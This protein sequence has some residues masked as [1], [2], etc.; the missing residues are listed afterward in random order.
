MS[1]YDPQRMSAGFMVNH[2]RLFRLFYEQGIIESD[3]HQRLHTMNGLLG[4]KKL[5][6]EGLHDYNLTSDQ[7]I[8]DDRRQEIGVLLA[9][10]KI[11]DVGW[12][13]ITC[14]DGYKVPGLKTAVEILKEAEI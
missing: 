3:Q 4:E 10:I 1:K 8:V 9:Q 14:K 13:T 6:D 7:Q 2:E 11:A 12:K 5:L